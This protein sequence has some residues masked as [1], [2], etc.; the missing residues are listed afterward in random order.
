MHA[1]KAAGPGWWLVI[2]YRNSTDVTVLPLAGWSWSDEHGGWV[3]TFQDDGSV[4]LATNLGSD[5]TWRSA[6]D[7]ELDQ[8]KQ[9]L[10]ASAER[11]ASE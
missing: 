9:E 5:S 11:K 7:S 2:A 4:R 8:V 10:L 6:T 3:P 1:F